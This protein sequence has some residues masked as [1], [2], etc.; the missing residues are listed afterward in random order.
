MT[1]LPGLTPC[2]ADEVAHAGMSA[3]RKGAGP[4]LYV[5]GVPEI[6]NE[7]MIRKHFSVWGEVRPTGQL[8]TS[9]VRMAVM[10]SQDFGVSYPMPVL[11]HALCSCA[12]RRRLLSKR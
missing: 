3:F 4:R 11:I 2:F 5:G 6:V 9:P 8:D 12:G 1:F 7:A 10:M